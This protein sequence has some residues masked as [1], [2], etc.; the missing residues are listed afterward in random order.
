MSHLLSGLQRHSSHSFI[1]RQRL[2][3]PKLLQPE[4][5]PCCGVHCWLMR[6]EAC[7]QSVQPQ[8]TS[9]EQI[10]GLGGGMQ[11][12]RKEKLVQH[13]QWLKCTLQLFRRCNAQQSLDLPDL[14]LLPLPCNLFQCSCISFTAYEA[15]ECPPCCFSPA[16]T[17]QSSNIKHDKAPYLTCSTQFLLLVSGR[18]V[19]CRG[20]GQVTFQLSSSLSSMCSPARASSCCTFS[21]LPV[22]AY[23]QDSSVTWAYLD[24]LSFTVLATCTCHRHPL[25]QL[26]CYCY[27]ASS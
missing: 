5:Y 7:Q 4:A 12:S 1:P 25:H 9:F 24:I 27:D 15:S 6:H 23:A 8:T 14:L 17:S 19:C 2:L 22:P 3:Q 13:M 26:H 10:S 20:D 21:T 16:A 11:R 18:Y